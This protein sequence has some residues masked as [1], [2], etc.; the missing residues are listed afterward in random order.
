[1]KNEKTREIK[2]FIDLE[3]GDSYSSADEALKAKQ[4]K[5][6]EQLEGKNLPSFN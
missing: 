5:Q 2:K 4:A 1:M 3:N 6:T